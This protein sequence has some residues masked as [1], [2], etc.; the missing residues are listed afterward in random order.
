MGVERQFEH[1]H[2]RERVDLQRR[3]HSRGLQRGHTT[4]RLRSGATVTFT[5]PITDLGSDLELDAPATLDLPGQ[6]LSVATLENNG[7]TINGGGTNLTVIGSM[8][9][10]GG[11]VTGSGTLDIPGGANLNLGEGNDTTE[12]LDSMVLVTRHGHMVDRH[13]RRHRRWRTQQHARGRIRL[14]W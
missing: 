14:P 7:G 11:S 1:Q 9:R 10:V 2:R 5:A 12:T 3:H 4:T 13:A 8:S 6:S